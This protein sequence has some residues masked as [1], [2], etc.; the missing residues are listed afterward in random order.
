MLEEEER[1]R[2]EEAD[3]YADR[4]RREHNRDDVNT[5]GA[6]QRTQITMLMQTMMLKVWARRLELI[7]EEEQRIANEDNEHY[8]L[9]QES[10]NIAELEALFLEAAAEGMSGTTED[11]AA[12]TTTTTVTTTTTSWQEIKK[13]TPGYAWKSVE[14]AD[15]LALKPDNLIENLKVG[16]KKYTVEVLRGKA[17]IRITFPI[18]IWEAVSW[19]WEKLKWSPRAENRPE[20]QRQVDYTITWMEL[21]IDFELS[22][23][24][25]CQ[26]DTADK[27]A[28]GA[29]AVL[30]KHII[31]LIMLVRGTPGHLLKPHFG[32]TQQTSSLAREDLR[33]RQI[34]VQG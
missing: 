22:T 4:G 21:V 10:A 18:R 27:A 32:V 8:E 30:L 6:Q 20:D 15:R 19:W 12:A 25:M 26:K 33:R 2:N 24:V 7:N 14:S 5:K 28:W 13:K 31:K 34:L 23:G 1:R 16:Q 9:E 29:R 17:R 11:E 3:W